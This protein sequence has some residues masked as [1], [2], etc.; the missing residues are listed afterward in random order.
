MRGV[1]SFEQMQS[2]YNKLGEFGSMGKT[3]LMV[4]AAL[5]GESTRRP[6]SN[7]MN[8]HHHNSSRWRAWLERIVIFVVVFIF[9]I[10][11]YYLFLVDGIT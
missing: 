4:E 2:Q 10:S 6:S 11:C 3:E 1:D 8:S 7:L 5:F 9:S